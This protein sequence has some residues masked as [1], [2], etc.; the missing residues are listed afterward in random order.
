MIPYASGTPITMTITSAPNI[1]GIVG[2]G[3]CFSIPV[4][5][6]GI[7]GTIDTTS[8]PDFA[9]SAARDG[10]ITSMSAF[11]NLTATTVVGGGTT[12]YIQ[13]Q[14]YSATTGNSFTPISNAYVILTPSFDNASAAGDTFS[15]TTTG[16]SIPIT[17]GT[18]LLYI[19]LIWI[20]ANRGPSYTLSGYFSGGVA[21]S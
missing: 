15:G 10:T 18:R 4:A 13:A 7:T 21:I 20:S 11:I 1:V 17:I 14:L 5:F 3:S 8:L 2:F 16:L 6:V 19:V 12:G 9:F